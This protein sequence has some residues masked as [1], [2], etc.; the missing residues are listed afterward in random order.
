MY[1]LRPLANGLRTDHPVPDLPFVDDSHI[2]LEDPRELEAVGRN[3]GGGM[4]GRYD[5]ERSAGGWRAFTTDPLRSEFAW[6]VRYHPDHGRTVVLVRDEDAS[7][8]HAEWHGGPLLFRAGGYWWD[9]ATW[10]RPGQVWDAA[11]EDF[12]RTPVPAARAVT[13]DQL[14]DGTAD[15]DA[16]RLLKVV[17]FDPDASLSGRWTDHLALWAKHRAD[18]GDDFPLDQCVLQVSAPELAADQLL[19]VTEFAGLA[20]IAASTLRS[21]ASRGEGNVPLPQATLS[22]RSAWSRPVAQDWVTQR[23]RENVASA[24]AGPDPEALPAGVSDLRERLTAAFQSL[25]WGRPQTRKRWVLRHRNEPDV[26]EISNDLALHVAT[27]L[28][29]IIP[30]EHLAVTVR[31]AV[32]D[33]LAEQHGW[34]T[35]EGDDRTHHYALT[36][37]VAKTLDWLIRHH[38]DYGQY[39]L[40]DIV[41]EAQNRLDIPRDAVADALLRSL[42]MDGN[43]DHAS[44]T[45]YLDLALPPEKTR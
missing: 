18:H 20:G 26:R 24:V 13:A 7:E 12:V 25:L 21:Y 31:H 37:P 41:R 33:E 10:Y 28:D 8:L 45:K 17:P 38:P 16:G 11:D 5:L 42:S 32:L 3:R 22:G 30:T 4:W 9:G 44:L 43:L 15:P 14:L 2:P 35:D 29:D 34:D 36:T 39:T 23:S 19:G 1:T 40:G 6:C 27:R